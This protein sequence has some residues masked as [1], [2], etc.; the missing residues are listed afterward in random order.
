MARRRYE[1]GMEVMKLNGPEKCLQ[2]ALLFS[3]AFAQASPH[4]DTS[5]ESTQTK[6]ALPHNQPGNASR[7]QTTNVDH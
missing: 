2:N 4:N 5:A 3:Q 6:K 7:L 1:I